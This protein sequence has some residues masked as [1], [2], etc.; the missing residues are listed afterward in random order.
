MKASG[1]FSDWQ[2]LCHMSMPWHQGN[3]KILCYGFFPGKLRFFAAGKYR[4]KNERG[5]VND[6]FRLTL[7]NGLVAG[8]QG[9]GESSKQPAGG[10]AS[11]M[12]K[13]LDLEV[14]SRK[15]SK[16][17]TELQ[18]TVSELWTSAMPL[19]TNALLQSLHSSK[20]FLPPP[21]PPVPLCWT[22]KVRNQQLVSGG[23][24]GVRR[25]E[26]TPCLLQTC[27]GDG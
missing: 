7:L 10:Q 5:C 25:I 13:E 22:P 18:G 15:F 8:S 2:N 26:E 27:G 11:L 21:P 17:I 3:W 6:S 20:S 1:G 9:Y 12:T 24:G 23:E 16:E 19:G 4:N 14:P